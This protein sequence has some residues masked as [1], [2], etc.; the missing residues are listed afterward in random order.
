MLYSVKAIG[1]T[2]TFNKNLNYETRDVISNI[3][4]G[5]ARNII[6]NVAKIDIMLDW[7]VFTWYKYI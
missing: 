4:K 7:L 6:N 1:V 5:I 3:A 2:I